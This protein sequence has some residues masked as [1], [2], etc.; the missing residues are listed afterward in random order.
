M[1]NP[2]LLVFLLVDMLLVVGAL[3]FVFS[4]TDSASPSPAPDVSTTQTGRATEM[5]AS[6][7]S[8]DARAK[9]LDAFRAAHDSRDRQG[10]EALIW[11]DHADPDALAGVTD[12]LTDDFEAELV[13]AQI[14]PLAEND[15]VEYTL[16][17]VRYVPNLPPAGKLIATLNQE[18]GTSTTSLLVGYHER[19]Y[20]IVSASPAS[21]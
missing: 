10:M 6:I 16:R 5:P 14:V 21:E 20:W 19:R 15:P 12:T 17:G 18:T 7:C 3:L 9:F 4:G 2:K 13:D 8:E 1:M 11:K